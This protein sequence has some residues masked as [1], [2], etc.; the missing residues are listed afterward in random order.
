MAEHASKLIATFTQEVESSFRFL[1][2]Q[3]GFKQDAGLSDFGSPVSKLK[4]LNPRKVPGTFWFIERFVNREIRIEIGFG[5][6]EFIVEADWWYQKESHGFAMWEIF[7]A[8]GA[9][10][11]K[12]GGSAWVTSCEF[13]EQTVR[14]MA[15]STKENI[16]LF[17]KPSEVLI[18][19]ALEIRGSR[20]RYDQKKQKKRNLN[21]ARNEAASAFREKD[22]QK[23]I[24]LLSPYSEILSEADNK[25]IHLCRKY[26]KSIHHIN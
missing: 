23:V 25:K 21:R 16:D 22:Y 5:D 24:E 19:R 12:I 9:K 20:L 17:I 26:G 6:R 2:D 7:N 10:D 11:N 13:M 1:V 14:E 15:K 8:A 4:R 3:Y 18:D